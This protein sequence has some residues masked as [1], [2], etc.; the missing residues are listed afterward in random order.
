MSHLS[1]I[2]FGC[3]FV[4]V[5]VCQFLNENIF[6]RN[7]DGIPLENW[8]LLVYIPIFKIFFTVCNDSLHSFFVFK[9][10]YGLC[11]TFIVLSLVFK[12]P[13]HTQL[14]LFLSSQFNSKRK[15]LKINRKSQ[16]KGQSFS[17]GIPVLKHAFSIFFT[18]VFPLTPLLLVQWKPFV[19]V[20]KKM[21]IV[22]FF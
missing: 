17:E 10:L 19:I 5:N 1:I 22:I 6:S 14:Y 18:Q 12:W 2:I 13:E 20:Q 7:I 11:T 8:L 21:E 4:S 9:F 16:R 15:F 3:V